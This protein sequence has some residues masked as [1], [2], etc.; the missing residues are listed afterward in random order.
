MADGRP[1]AHAGGDPHEVVEQ[2][3]TIL[4]GLGGE[5]LSSCWRNA[6]QVRDRVNGLFEAGSI[7]LR[8]RGRAEQLFWQV[9]GRIETMG[10]RQTDVPAERG[11]W[12][13]LLED[14]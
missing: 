8:Q 5:S 6:L 4:K 11:E 14:T 12:E 7:A 13:T 2:L 9:A 1:P 10:R 3:A